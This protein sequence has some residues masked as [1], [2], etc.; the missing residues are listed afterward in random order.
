VSEFTDEDDAL[1]EALEVEVPPRAESSRTSREERVVAGFEQ[2]QRF[3]SLHGRVPARGDDIDLLERIY[4]VRLHRIRALSEFRPLLD[5]LDSQG[6]LSE[7]QS[8]S[9]AADSDLDDDALLA[10]LGFGSAP[11][12]IAD[13]RHVRS[14]AEKRAAEEIANRKPCDDFDKFRPMFQ[15]VKKELDAGIRRSRPFETMDQIQQG[16]WFIVGGQVAFVESVGDE[17]QTE[18]GRRDSRLR[19]IYDNGT[20]SDVLLR[21]LQRAMHRDGA[22]RAISTPDAGPLFSG[23]PD[24][25]DE[26][27]GTIYVLQTKSDIPA[28]AANREILHKIGVTGGSV[29]RRIYDARLDATFLLADV[30]IIAT[31]KLANINRTRLEALI[32]RFFDAARLNI[33]IKDRFGYPVVPREWFLVPL[34]A[35]D[36]AVKRIKDGSI[37]EYRYDLASAS[38]RRLGS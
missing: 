29:E 26:S 7:N 22:G 32:H 20:E 2:I 28:L 30:E 21:S 3:V 19:V 6:L 14:T 4:A 13:L 24:V 25:G 36:E 16:Q 17:F 1:L 37:T 34:Y 23:V 27:S 12:G 31:Y 18:Y 38:L 10:E 35:I 5:P 15:Q 33:E 11:Q 8:L 9:T